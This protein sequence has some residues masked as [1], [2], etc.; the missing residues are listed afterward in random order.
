[1]V[2]AQEGGG[3]RRGPGAG[4]GRGVEFLKS[5]DTNGDGKIS[6]DEL[7]AKMKQEAEQR[8]DQVDG[9][10]DGVV[11]QAEIASIGE[12]MGEGN[13]RPG[14]EGGFRRP[15]GEGGPEGGFR[16][17]P[18]GQRPEGGSPEGR[19]PEG[20]PPGGRP[21]GGPPGQGGPQGPGGMGMV[22]PEEAFGRMDKNSDGGVDL[23]EYIEGS[24]QE[25]EGRFK[26][27]DE[28]SDG[29]VSLDEMK[30]AVQRLREAMRGRMG[31]GE[32]GARRPG[33]E[34]GPEGGFRRPPGQSGGEGGFRRPPEG[35][36]S[37]RPRPPVEG[38][39]PKPEG[40]APKK[41]GDAPKKEI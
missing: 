20:G 17:P 11:D 35:E 31:G 1:M 28:N 30:S 38:E 25:F 13:R 2:M 5:A 41:E 4:G 39:Q 6:K 9:N 33:G 29:K 10:K 27:M 23:S 24:K 40:D 15:G 7:V 8:F 21:E 19:R 37:G 32:G 16:R 22:N 36:G 18:E 3:E 26:R 12:R 34:G 14:G